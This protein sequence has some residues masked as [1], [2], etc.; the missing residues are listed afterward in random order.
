MAARAFNNQSGL[1]GFCGPWRP[2]TAAVNR[3]KLCRCLVKT[4]PANFTG[5]I[6]RFDPF[7]P[8]LSRERKSEG[9]LQ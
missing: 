3:D 6:V 9:T 8:R 1:R 5:V 2:G 4:Q 7:K